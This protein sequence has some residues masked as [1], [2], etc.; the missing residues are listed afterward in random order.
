MY[1][2]WTSKT[3]LMS[4][5]ILS[6]I[7][8]ISPCIKGIRFYFVAFACN[9]VLL[10]LPYFCSFNTITQTCPQHFSF[11]TCALN[12]PFSLHEH[13]S[14]FSSTTFNFDHPKSSFLYCFFKK[15]ALTK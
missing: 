11:I 4:K 8:S 5:D 13:P 1:E 12:F 9:L 6:K 15:L 14:F 10:I 2:R 7:F 3:F